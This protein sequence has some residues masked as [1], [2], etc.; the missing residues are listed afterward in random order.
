VCGVWR[1]LT[2]VIPA[3]CAQSDTNTNTQYEHQAT[4]SIIHMPSL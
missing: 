1:W 3:A 4:T 2:G